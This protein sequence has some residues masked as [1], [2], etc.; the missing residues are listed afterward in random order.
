G[1]VPDGALRQNAGRA[2]WPFRLPG[3]TSLRNRSARECFGYSVFSCRKHELS[4]AV[5][6]GVACQKPRI[7]CGELCEFACASAGRYARAK[8]AGRLAKYSFEGAIEL[9]QRLE[10]YVVRDFADAQVRIQKAVARVFQA[11]TR[12][13]ISKL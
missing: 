9:R 3:S 2:V 4:C 13:V 12:H 8:V 10:P 5:R 1:R 7:F 11:H 6:L